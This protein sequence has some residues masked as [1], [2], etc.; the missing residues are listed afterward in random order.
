[1]M[2]TRSLLFALVAVYCSFIIVD[3][4]T[5]KGVITKNSQQQQ[6]RK[7]SGAN[8]SKR[9]SDYDDDVCK[10]AD[11]ETAY[12]YQ[13]MA[14]TMLTG[15]DDIANTG[16]EDTE[17]LGAFFQARVAD[18]STPDV[19]WDIDAGTRQFQLEG[20]EN[21]KPLWVDSFST[22]EFAFHQWSHWEVCLSGKSV[23]EAACRYHGVVREY[24]GTYQDI[25]GVIV[26]KFNAEDLID[27]AFVQRF[28]TIDRPY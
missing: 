19:I 26:V 18:V 25:F 4:D 23:V 11:S 7:T 10:I 1:M 14:N 2:H 13:R 5:I 12:Y 9:G 28:N 22:R 3:A 27:Y 24:G 21:V 15:V 6:Q 8:K 20:I 16:F 17:E